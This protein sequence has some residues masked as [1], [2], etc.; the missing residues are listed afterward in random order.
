MDSNESI[1]KVYLSLRSYL[2]NAA[3]GIVPPREVEDI[4]QEAY[5]RVCQI[6]NPEEIKQPRSFLFK[7]VRNLA[8]NHA[9]RA[10]NR[11]IAFTEDP[12]ETV[13]L[14]RE[15]KD[16][17]LDQAVTNEEFGRFCESVRAL[18]VQ[19]RRA[20]VLKKVYGCSQKEIARKM[21]LSESTVEKHIASGIR[22]CT[23]LMMESSLE[24]KDHAMKAGSAKKRHHKV[25]SIHGVRR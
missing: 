16:E 8:L 15:L 5:V 25:S 21:G 22:R 3:S 24:G 7:I 17:T 9:K 20:F 10:D 1:L 6:K 12:E 19:C 14:S 4:V 23:S 11:L 2:A 18:P 13:A